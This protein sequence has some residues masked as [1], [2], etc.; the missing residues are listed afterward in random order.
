MEQSVLDYYQMQDFVTYF[1]NTY[2]LM[3]ICSYKARLGFAN[4]VES[5]ISSPDMV[6][7]LLSMVDY[8]MWLY[9]TGMAPQGSATFANSQT[10]AAINL[11]NAYVQLGGASSPA[12]ATDYQTWPSNQRV[13]FC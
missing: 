5:T 1:I 10:D 11:A 4:F 2:N 13:V 8:S 6:N 3:S 7:S 12:N 9:D